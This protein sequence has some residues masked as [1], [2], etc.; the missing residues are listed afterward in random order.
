M[1]DLR[2]TVT[3]VTGATSG[4]GA[5]TARQL[6]ELGA[7]VVL[8]GRRNHRLKEIADELGNERVAWA[9]V[10]IRIP[11]QVEGLFSCAVDTFGGVDCLVAN[12]GVGAYG[13][14]LDLSDG[15]VRELIDT[16]VAGT[17]WTVRQAVPLLIA[18]GGGDIVLVSSVAGLRG[19]HDEAV[20]AATKHAV[21]GL[22]GSLDRELRPHGIRVTAM[23]PGAT[24]TEFAMGRGRTPEMPQLETMMRADDVADAI[25]YALRQPTSLRTLLWSMR[26]IV[27]EN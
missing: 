14:I 27:S 9:E 7:Q 23:C 11:E 8:G 5:A 19:R 25:T 18:R 15:D 12:A 4:I 3:V 21:V 22:A 16:N 6:H 24:D 20:Y 17:V 1:R 10:D 13:G 26:S 2:D